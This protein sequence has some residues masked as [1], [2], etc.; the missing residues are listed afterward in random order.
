LLKS[1][2]KQVKVD[3]FGKKLGGT[4]LR[5]ATAALVV[6]IGGYHHHRQLRLAPFDLAIPGIL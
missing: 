6:A 1:H 4:Q 3:R 2:P 5:G